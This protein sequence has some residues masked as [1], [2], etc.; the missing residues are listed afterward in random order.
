MLV[1]LWRRYARVIWHA[2]RINRLSIRSRLEVKK[3]S[4][5]EDFKRLSGKGFQKLMKYKKWFFLGVLILKLKKL[6]TILKKKLDK[7]TLPYTLHSKIWHRCSLYYNEIS[8]KNTFG[9]G[10]Y[11]QLENVMSTSHKTKKNKIN[12]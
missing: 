11:T 8:T 5:Y 6:Y 4:K 12:I 1:L 2:Y 7:L 3:K 10:K 9:N